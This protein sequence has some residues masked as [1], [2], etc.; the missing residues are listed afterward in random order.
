[1]VGVTVKDMQV[2]DVMYMHG[3][4]F[5]R[6]GQ[7]IVPST[8]LVP[9]GIVHSTYIF[10]VWSFLGQHIG[11]NFSANVVKAELE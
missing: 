11:T 9:D 5:D 3:Y 4:G 8:P 6:L 7:P 10:Q 1:M 2:S